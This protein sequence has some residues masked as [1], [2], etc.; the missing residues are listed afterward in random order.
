M[1][2]SSRPLA[3]AIESSRK[4]SLNQ[5]FLSHQ[6]ASEPMSTHPRRKSQATG[7]YAIS[8]GGVIPSLE[9]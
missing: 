1:P 7:K 2:P 5:V 6:I 3:L 9:R 4:Y 8:D